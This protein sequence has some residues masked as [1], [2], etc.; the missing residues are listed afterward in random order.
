MKIA[1]LKSL[2]YIALVFTIVPSILVLA[3]KMDI[4]TNKNLMAAA[5]L[6]WFVTAP[7][8]MNRDKDG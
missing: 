1:I 5:M 6:V 4:E 7:F 8:W 2:S 3:G